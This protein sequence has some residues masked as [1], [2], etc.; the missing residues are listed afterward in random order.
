M[1]IGTRI[2]TII[3][4]LAASTLLGGWSFDRQGPYCLQDRDSTNC[5]YPTLEACVVTTRGAGGYCYPNPKYVA[6][7]PYPEPRPRRNKW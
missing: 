2:L 7:R 3:G 6:E 5:G 1:R 4:A